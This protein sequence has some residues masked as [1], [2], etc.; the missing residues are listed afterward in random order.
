M[1]S[2]IL[3]LGSA[4]FVGGYI[5][6]ELQNLYN[7]STPTRQEL[8]LKDY[9]S[10]QNYFSSK[11]FD[12]VINCAG[13]MENKLFPFDVAAATENLLIFNNLYAVRQKYHRLINIGS[14]AEFDRCAN[15][16]CANEEQIFLKT[17]TDHYGLSKN[18]V[19]RMSYNTDNFYTLRLF[20]LFGKTES[21]SRLLKKV[22]AGEHIEINDRYFDYFY[23]KDLIPILD[24]FINKTPKYK[25]I[26]VVYPEKIRLSNFINQFCEIHGLTK[27]NIRISD[28]PGLSYTGSSS[29]LINLPI[30][31]SGLLQGL[32]DYYEY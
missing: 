19:S 5:V 7:L 12:V 1:A 13:N 28:T 15:I 14:G 32:K 9:N 23:I 4:G 24:Y 29:K 16:D 10:V 2:D 3:V 20:G 22:L 25:D 30:N 11:T 6:Q 17:P 8:D 26:N 31:F 27:S 21:K 18:I